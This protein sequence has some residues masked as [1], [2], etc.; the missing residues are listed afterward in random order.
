MTEEREAGRLEE[1]ERI[2]R[3]LEEEADVTPCVED[4]NVYRSAAMLVRADFSYDGTE[5]YEDALAAAERRL[6][7]LK[8]ALQRLGSM[9]AFA[10]AGLVDPKRDVELVAR[11]DYA[12]RAETSA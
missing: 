7:A 12:R 8:A 1:R 9:E 10:R 6:A 4:A 11:I 2:A 5:E 3:R